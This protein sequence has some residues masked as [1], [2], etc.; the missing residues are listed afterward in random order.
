[1]EKSGLSGVVEA[2]EQDLGLL[3]PQTQRGEDAVEPIDQEHR[4]RRGVS[5]DGRSPAKR[6]R[7]GDRNRFRG[8]ESP[9]WSSNGNETTDDGKP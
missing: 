6:I 8:R 4:G 7:S 1:M 9:I 3:L 5:R 2:Q